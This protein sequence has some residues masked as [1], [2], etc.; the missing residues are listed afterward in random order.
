ML[1]S[2]MPADT[3]MSVISMKLFMLIINFL[4]NWVTVPCT[5]ASSK[6][7]IIT[8]LM[9][10]V[11]ESRYYYHL[12]SLVSSHFHAFVTQAEFE[13]ILKRG[14]NK[15]KQAL[16]YPSGRNLMQYFRRVIHFYLALKNHFPDTGK[17]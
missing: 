3:H 1:I 7:S 4:Q 5:T 9:E 6:H 15:G 12:K 16:S 14:S 2:Y 17:D 10:I 11:L 13:D 8:I